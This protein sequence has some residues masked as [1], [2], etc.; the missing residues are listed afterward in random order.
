[1]VEITQLGRF[2]CFVQTRKP[3]RKGTRVHVE[4]TE[5]GAT[6]VASG[7][8]AYVTRNG[9]GIVFSMVESESSEVLTNLV[10]PQTQTVSP[11]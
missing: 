6:F 10:V 2:G 8:V 1:M 7:V 3:Y 9:M 5:S 11:L 4:I